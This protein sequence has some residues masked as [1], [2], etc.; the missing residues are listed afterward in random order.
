MD[1]HGRRRR[2]EIKCVE[3]WRWLIFFE[4]EKGEEVDG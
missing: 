3:K 2:A 4:R 1:A